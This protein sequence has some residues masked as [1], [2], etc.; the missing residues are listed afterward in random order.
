MPKS[1][2]ADEETTTRRSGPLR[3]PAA[4]GAGTTIA[5][6]DF[7]KNKIDV[8]GFPDY[9]QKVLSSNTSLVWLIVTSNKFYLW[10][11]DGCIPVI[12]TT[13]G[14]LF[15]MNL[16]LS[17]ASVSDVSKFF[18]PDSKGSF[19]RIPES[20]ICYSATY[21]WSSNDTLYSSLTTQW[22][23]ANSKT[24]VRYS[25][26]NTASSDGCVFTNYNIPGSLATVDSDFFVFGS[27]NNYF[28]TDVDSIAFPIKNGQF[29][30]LSG[31]NAEYWN[32]FNTRFP[33]YNSSSKFYLIY[34]GSFPTA[35]S[36][37]AET[38]RGILG[39]LKA[40]PNKIKAFFTSL[41]DRISGFF[42]DL[43]TKI[44][45]LFIPSDGFFNTYFNDLKTFFAERFGFIYDLPA[46]VVT[47]LN[48][49]INYTPAESGYHIHFPE[50]STP[51]IMDGISGV[52]WQRII[53]EQDYYFDFLE[54]APFSTLYSGYRA[55][56]WLAY[57]F[58]L[59]NL[60]KSK[61][62]SIFGG[63]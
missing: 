59:I 2:A 19:S 22:A 29:S 42:D 34:S 55:F 47:I 3:A 10:V 13:N 23:V 43:F 60:A 6:P 21:S 32:G 52:G 17:N 36:Q 46:A 12:S 51:V 24:Y 45:G 18:Y 25:S 56:V 20:F 57:C 8:A 61:A 15:L 58:M 39:L 27:S 63:K 31:D 49:L 33:L 53:E 40:L 48:K 11:A 44:K 4:S 1:E 30:Y 54:Q 41:G 7:D 28:R 16:S 5:F 38:Q 50:V 26:S 37:Q 9:V 35:T 62:E 14:N